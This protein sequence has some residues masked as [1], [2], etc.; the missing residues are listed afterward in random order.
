M[1]LHDSLLYETSGRMFL[2]SEESE[3]EW[4][5]KPKAEERVA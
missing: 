1:Q 4:E 2:Q 5:F 3:H